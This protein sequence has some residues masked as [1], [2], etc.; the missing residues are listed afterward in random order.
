M[1][2]SWLIAH[3]GWR[4]RIAPHISFRAQHRT[5]RHASTQALARDHSSVESGIGNAPPAT[6]VAN[7]QHITA[8]RHVAP[9]AAAAFRGWTAVVTAR[10]K[11]A[12]S[13]THKSQKPDRARPYSML[14]VV[15]LCACRN[16]AVCCLLCHTRCWHT[17]KRTAIHA[18]FR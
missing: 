2:K 4:A 3:G 11:C 9:P 14:C 13:N 12:H 5:H 15:L 7:T 17:H 10:G 16:F 18:A 1:R 8:R 6:H